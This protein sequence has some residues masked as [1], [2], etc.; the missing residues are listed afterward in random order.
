VILSAETALWAQDRAAALV[1][2]LPRDSNAVFIVRVSEILKSPRAVQEQWSAQQAERFLHGESSVPP[3]VE[4]LVIGSLVRPAGAEAAWSAALVAVPPATRLES[5]AHT[6]GEIE[7]LGASRAVRGT[8]DAIFLDLKPGLLGVM[9]PAHRQDAARWSREIAAAKQSELSP[10]LRDAGRLPGQI[11]LAMDLQDMFDPARVRERLAADETLLTAPEIRTKLTGQLLKIRGITMEITIGEAIGSKVTLAFADPLQD[12]AKIF[13][14]IFVSILGETG[15]GIDEFDG[16]SSVIDGSNLV[17]STELS[18]TSLR[19]I[20]SLIVPPPPHAQVADAA[21]SPTASP[22]PAANVT[23]LPPKPAVSVTPQS[24]TRR[25]FLAVSK[26]VDDLK[27]ANRNAKNYERTATW[28]DNF[29]RKINDLSTVGVDKDVLAYGAATAEKFR[30]LAASLRGQAVQVAASQGTLSYNYSY[31]PGWVQADWWGGVG[32]RAPTTSISS[33][34]R[35][36]R[37]QQAKAIEAG[38]V[39]RT[40]IWQAI[41]DERAAMQLTMRQRYG[42]DVLR[43]P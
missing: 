14:R 27:V 43:R 7:T 38:A 29:A 42:D 21:A 32:Y 5:L 20:L 6:S 41:D 35:Q 28:H 9:S 24:A 22:T 37:E 13:Q 26:M 15:V 12:S 23:V 40:K 39:D 4:A 31:D 18:E 33:N 2:L 30:A 11:V 1:P 25:Y 17:L 8:Q 34:L 3:W 16:A 10:F 36:V 19:R